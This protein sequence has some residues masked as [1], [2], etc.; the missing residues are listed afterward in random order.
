MWQTVISAALRALPSVAHFEHASTGHDGLAL[1]RTLRPDLVLL[2]LVLSDADGVA[3]ALE[4]ARLPFPP[5]VLLLSARRD[6]AALYAA[7]EPHIAGLLLKSHG[8]LGQLPQAIGTVA[9]GGK[10]YPT[11]VREALRRFRAD[12]QA[13]FKLLSPRQIALLPHFA[14]AES[15]EEIATGLGLSAHT[16]KSHRQTVMRKLDL[17]G[18][19][20]LTHWAI[21]NGFGGAALPPALQAPSSKLQAP[22][23]TSA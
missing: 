13:F 16:V 9:A 3:L 8:A 23:L 15:D 19:A 5:R 22:D 12:P 20:R 1:T 2:D 14:R 10:Y 21:V 6:A 7:S 18:P 17:H 4:L 11:E